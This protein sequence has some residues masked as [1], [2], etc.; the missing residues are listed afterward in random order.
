MSINRKLK[1]WTVNRS[2]TPALVVQSW[3]MPTTGISTPVTIDGTT[4]FGVF[5]TNFV[6]DGSRN[7]GVYSFLKKI[8]KKALR[9][10]KKHPSEVFRLLLSNTDHMMLMKMKADSI[11]AAID[12]ANEGHQTALAEK[13]GKEFEIHLTEDKMILAGFNKCITEEMVVN[14]F[15]K[16]INDKLSL[17]YLANY[18][19]PIP[20][21][22]AEKIRSAEDMMVFDNY[23]IL[24]F[25]PLGEGERLTEEEERKR[26]DPIIFGII[27]NVRKFYFIGDWQDD[28]C[29]LT[30]DVLIEKLGIKPE[31]V[32]INE[33]VNNVNMAQQAAKELMSILT[34]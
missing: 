23:V 6:S 26:R 19:R 13:I 14:L 27:Q 22:I 33:H 5:A 30:M 28:Q 2:E 4:Q 31:S 17:T 16:C 10:T 11:K 20:E 1:K 21:A 24:H 34:K 9:I 8:V 32:I 7:V 25:D 15:E 3:N 29:N 18:V 12:K